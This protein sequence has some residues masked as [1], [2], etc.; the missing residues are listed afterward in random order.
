MIQPVFGSMADKHSRPWMM[1]LGIFMS[2]C[3]ISMLGFLNSYWAMF[4]AVAF[5]GIG[6]ALFHPDGGRMANY[7]AGERKGRGISNF[8]VGGNLGGAVG[9]MLAVFGISHFGLKGTAILAV[10]AFLMAAFL[11][12]QTK[13]LAG[14]ANEGARAT[15]AAMAAGQKDDWK[16]FGK[17]TACHLPAFHFVHRH[18]HLHPPVLDERA[19]PVRC[20][21]RHHHHHHRFCRRSV[22]SHRRPSGRPAGLQPG[23]PLRSGNVHPLP[24][25]DHLLPVGGSLHHHAHSSGDVLESGVQPLCG[26]GTELLPNHV[27][28]ASGITMGL[29]SSFGGV[30]S[31]ILGKVGDAQGLP[32]VLWILAGVAV[33]ACVGSFFV[34]DAPETVKVP[35]SSQAASQKTN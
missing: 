29:A 12:T 22:H 10:P 11:L 4:V 18:D 9:P 3:G 35:T 32:T 19:S 8:S 21:L 2:G 33:V 26:S 17:L 23:H 30:V 15:K 13:T 5:T 27:G 6:S 31:P 25:G 1:C 16:G 24:A 20:P 14:F 28:L 7:V 34:P